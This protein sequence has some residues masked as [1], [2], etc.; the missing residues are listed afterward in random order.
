MRSLHFDTLRRAIAT[1]LSPRTAEYQQLASSAEL[2]VERRQKKASYTAIAKLLTRHG[3]RVHSTVV[4]DFRHG[5]LGEDRERRTR[6]R[7]ATLRRQREERSA[8]PGRLG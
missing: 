5:V 8:T 7:E 3:L 4:A 1:F 6:S 2:V